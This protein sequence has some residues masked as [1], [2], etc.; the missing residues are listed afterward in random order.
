MEIN[1]KLSKII[2]I[3]QSKELNDMAKR[4][5]EDSNHHPPNLS[6]YQNT[7]DNWAL[8]FAPLLANLGEFPPWHMF[9]GSVIIPKW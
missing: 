9:I 2:Q 6:Q 1:Q 3:E 7:A 4:I 8:G 5:W